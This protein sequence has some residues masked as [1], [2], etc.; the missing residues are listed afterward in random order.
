MEYY[1]KDVIYFP[2]D[3]TTLKESTLYRPVSSFSHS[4]EHPSCACLRDNGDEWPDCLPAYSSC[5]DE[6]NG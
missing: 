4:Y 3:D 1:S 6:P 2:E 5:I